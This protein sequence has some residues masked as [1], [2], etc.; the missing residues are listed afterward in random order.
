MLWGKNQLKYPVV[1]WSNMIH[2]EINF[3]FNERENLPDNLKHIKCK[4]KQKTQTL[5]GGKWQL[6]KWRRTHYYL[7]S[8]RQ[9]VFEI[10]LAQRI[11]LKSQ[12]C[13]SLC[14]Q[15]CDL[16][17]VM[18]KSHEFPSDVKS[19][20]KTRG[21]LG[22]LVVGIQKGL[23][24]GLVTSSDHSGS[25][26]LRFGPAVTESNFFSLLLKTTAVWAVNCDCVQA[27]L[28]Q[29]NNN[30]DVLIIVSRASVLFTFRSPFSSSRISC[31]CSQL[32]SRPRGQVT[33]STPSC[34]TG[35]NWTE[36]RS[37]Q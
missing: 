15:E 12:Y 13:P 20:R 24:M 9:G 35:G 14:E 29:L 25:R 34:S 16:W 4:R 2:A 32:P 36:P 19:H 23:S 31:M 37:N 27:S 26:H 21:T 3:L 33:P 18:E 6:W 8:Y 5:F 22:K 10:E 28:G 1:I 17:W 7:F 11:S 30:L